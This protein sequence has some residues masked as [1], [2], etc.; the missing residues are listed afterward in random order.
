MPD[1]ILERSPEEVAAVVAKHLAEAEAFK[2]TAAKEHADA[3]RLDAVAEQVEIE[4]A[5]NVEKREFEL[6][7]NTNHLV[8]VFNGEVATASVNACIDQLV[9]WHRTRPAEDIEIIFNSPG[10][11]VVAGLALW[12]VIQ[13][14]KRDHNVTTVAYGM[15]ASMA[16]ILLQAGHERIMGAE[17]WLMIHEASF[18][19]A[20]KIGEVE[21]T[22]EWIKMVQKRILRIFASRSHLSERQLENKWKRKDFWISSDYALE[23]G[24]IDSIR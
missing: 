11:S 24:L 21:D 16:G 6:A 14:I 9:R 23:L 17:S 20:G 10:G 12:D 4:L 2:A 7:A 15:A 22:V 8:Y 5:R 19:A 13:D 1:L 3:R 18:G